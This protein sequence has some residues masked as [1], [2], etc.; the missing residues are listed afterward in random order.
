MSKL[1]LAHARIVYPSVCPTAEHKAARLSREAIHVVSGFQVAGFPRVMGC[2]W[3]S[4]DR[5]CV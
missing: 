3:P 5:V 2:L 4:I 1:S